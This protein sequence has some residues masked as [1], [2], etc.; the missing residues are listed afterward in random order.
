MRKDIFCL[1]R[2]E[3]LHCWGGWQAGWQ[4]DAMCRWLLTCKMHARPI[5][6]RIIPVCRLHAWVHTSLHIAHH[7]KA[8]FRKFVECWTLQS[9]T[10]LNSGRRYLAFSTAGMLVRGVL[11]G[12]SSAV[13]GSLMPV[14]C[15]GMQEWSSQVSYICLHHLF[16]L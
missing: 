2:E 6:F 11:C 7:G 3:A 12:N 15:E 5:V 4:L 13:Q 10:L 14:R 8:S 16:A 9:V 1:V